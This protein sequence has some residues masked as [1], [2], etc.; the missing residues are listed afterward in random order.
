MTSFNN[1]KLGTGDALSSSEVVR[2]EKEED[3]S[4]GKFRSLL[5]GGHEEQPRE[6]DRRLFLK[7]G[8]ASRKLS[9]NSSSSPFDMTN[10]SMATLLLVI[11]VVFFVVQKRKKSS[12][13][14]VKK[15]S[16]YKYETRL[17]NNNQR[18]THSMLDLDPLSVY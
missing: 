15:W 11:L 9:S 8:N 14:S 13:N 6:Q 18:F 1:K 17:N 10:W 12:S 2:E 3:T 4:R 16:Q 5:R 7:R